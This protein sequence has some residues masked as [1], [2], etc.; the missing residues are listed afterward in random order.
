MLNK[1]AE[2]R[3]IIRVALS[4]IKQVE[5]DTRRELSAEDVVAALQKEAKMRRESIDELQGAGRDEQASHAR[6]ELEILES[7]LPRQLSRAEI[8]SLVLEA[9]AQTGAS[10]PKDM[11]KVMGALMPRVKGLADG[12]LVNQV[13]RDVLNR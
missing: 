7:F 13:V 11:G 8:E 2:R 10:G 3:D 9:V 1:D 6:H 5:V 4:V 12:N